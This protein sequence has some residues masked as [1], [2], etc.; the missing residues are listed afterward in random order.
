VRLKRNVNLWSYKYLKNLM[1]EFVQYR[2]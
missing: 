2:T 1:Q